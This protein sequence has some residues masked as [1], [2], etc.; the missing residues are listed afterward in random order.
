MRLALSLFI[1]MTGM[2][3]SCVEDEQAPFS[4]GEDSGFYVQLPGYGSFIYGSEVLLK[5][6]MLSEISKVY[7]EKA[8][9]GNSD[10]TSSANQSRIEARITNKTNNELTFVIPAGSATGEPMIYYERGGETHPL[11]VLP[12]SEPWV[13]L[14][15][16]ER[17]IILSGEEPLAD[18]KIYF[19]CLKYDEDTGNVT[20]VTGEWI[21]S[22]FV[23][24][25]MYGWTVEM[26]CLG[27]TYVRWVHRGED[28]LLSGV[29]NIEPRH[30]IRFPQADWYC[31]G[32]EVTLAGGLFEEG[33]TITLN[34]V[35]A[36]IVSIDTTDD[37]LTFRIPENVTGYQSVNLCRYGVEYN[38]AEIVVYERL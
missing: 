9:T 32:D 1:T 6:N 26:V 38:L 33:D 34:G 22:S 13:F 12:V 24:S 5:G 35:P 8:N 36:E 17:V 16:E 3:T 23:Y 30:C 10:G 19:Q 25:E 4:G 29:V 21:E 27:A 28:I 7:V 2:F 31:Q 20:P 14:Y 15:E 11:N 18:D 37:A